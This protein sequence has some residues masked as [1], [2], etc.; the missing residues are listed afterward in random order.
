MTTMETRPLSDEETD[1]Q[2]VEAFKK[3]LELLRG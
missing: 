3:A 1:T 2:V